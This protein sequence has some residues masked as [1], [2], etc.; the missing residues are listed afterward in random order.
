MESQAEHHPH[1]ADSSR[2]PMGKTY[3]QPALEGQRDKVLC[4]GGA[5]ESKGG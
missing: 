2:E 3:A 1:A 5:V 4:Q